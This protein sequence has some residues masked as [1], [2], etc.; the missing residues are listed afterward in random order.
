M[1]TD[2]GG[3]GIGAMLSQVDDKGREY[4]VSFASRSCNPAEKNYSYGDKE[5]LDV[6]WGVP[7]SRDCLFEQ[8][9]SH[10]NG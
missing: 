8:T 5:C 3:L 7:H 1:S 2:W 6:V 10:S 9:I 4:A